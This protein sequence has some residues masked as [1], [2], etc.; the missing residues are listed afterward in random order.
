MTEAISAELSDH[1]NA[2]GSIV[3][4]GTPTRLGTRAAE[5]LGLRVET[6]EQPLTGDLL[7]LTDLE[8]DRSEQGEM[9]GVLRHIELLSDGGISAVRI[10][11]PHTGSA[12]RV[13]DEE[14]RERVYATARRD[15]AWGGGA[16]MW[17]RGSS[18]PAFAEPDERGV[19]AQVPHDPDSFADPGVLLRDVAGMAGY[20]ISHA[21]R[22]PS[23]GRAVLGLT[24]HRPAFW[25]NASL[26]DTPARV[27]PRFPL[28]LPTL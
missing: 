22:R 20:L 8:S 17:V 23:S 10:V 14:G 6:G 21:L 7:L 26:P 13:Q 1:L 5:L 27:R 12:V 15:P 9:P 28:G 19:P 18:P 4:Y 2:G 3:V 11:D 24:R 16:A 25:L